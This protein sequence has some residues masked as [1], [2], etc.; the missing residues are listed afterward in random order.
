MANKYTQKDSQNHIKPTVQYHYTSIGMVKIQNS[1]KPNAGK[2]VEQ[3]TRTIIHCWW[4]FKSTATLEVSLVSFYKNKHN[5]F[6]VTSRNHASLYLP[7]RGENLCW[8][9]NLSMDVYS[10]FI[11]NGKNLEAT[12]LSFSRSKWVRK[13]RHTQSKQRYLAV[14]KQTNKQRVIKPWENWKET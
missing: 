12:K 2:D 4:K 3:P 1:N 6:T 5:S 9:K 8:H 11:Y 10:S 14:E 7:K 13:L